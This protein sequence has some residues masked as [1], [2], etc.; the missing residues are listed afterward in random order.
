MELRTH[1]WQ[2]SSHTTSSDRVDSRGSARVILR[3][4]I[5]GGRLGR[6][7]LQPAGFPFFQDGQWS[8]A[9]H[10]PYNSDPGDPEQSK[11]NILSTNQSVV[12]QTNLLP[13][14]RR[15]KTTRR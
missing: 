13:R 11:K 6:H 3:Q 2:T 8:L 4:D 10:L 5:Q 9:Y 1:P 7:S 15:G 14:P 12:E